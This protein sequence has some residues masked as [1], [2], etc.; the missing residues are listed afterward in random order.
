MERIEKSVLREQSYFGIPVDEMSGFRPA[1]AQAKSL[2]RNIEKTGCAGNQEEVCDRFSL[3]QNE[4]NPFI[5]N[6]K[7]RFQFAKQAEA[8]VIIYSLSGA[9]MR[10]L[11]D[12]TLGPGTHIVEWDGKDNSG[13]SME[14]GIYLCRLYA[15]VCTTTNKMIYLK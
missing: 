2:T 7:I 5:K 1:A 15:G 14:S 11:L 4:P 9:L 13:E 8:K 6:T 10:T 3:E 12:S